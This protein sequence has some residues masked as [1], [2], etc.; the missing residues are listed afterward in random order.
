M[1]GALA[2]APWPAPR[3]LEAV[4][5][6]DQL[7]AMSAQNGATAQ[8]RYDDMRASDLIAVLWLGTAGPG[9][10]D[11]APING[12][13]MGFV[14]VSVPVSAI[15]ANLGKSVTLFYAVLRDGEQYTSDILDLAVLALSQADLTAPTVPQTN[16]TLVLDLNAFIGDA[17]VLAVR[18]P[19]ITAGQRIWLRAMGTAS[20]GTAR[21]ITLAAGRVITP[22]EFAQGLNITLPRVDLQGLL[23][24][25][26]WL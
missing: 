10:P 19:L 26:P 12:S 24:P 5:N 6:P 1:N 20:D 25:S 11:L 21:V 2:T 14:D 4:Q 9:T 22:Q 23:A 17:Q 8:V 16:G 15:A 13:V 7:P 3:V 18:W